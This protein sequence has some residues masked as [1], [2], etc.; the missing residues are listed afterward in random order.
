MAGF[1]NGTLQGGVFF[2]AKQFGSVL[3]GFGPP[4]PQAGVVG[5][6]YID[7]QTFNLYEKRSTDATDPWGNFIFVVPS[8]QQAQLKWFVP[9]APTNDIGVN[10]DYALLWAGF[11]N[12]GL[13]PLIFGP[14]AAGA[15]PTSPAAVAVS[16]NPL[17]TAE[18]SVNVGATNIVSGEQNN[19]SIAAAT[20]LTVPATATYAVVT[21]VGGPLFAT[22]DGSTPSS[23]NFAMQVAQGGSLPV[24]GGATLLA[25]K[26][27][28]TQMSVS[29]WN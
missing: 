22:Y 2:Q 10:G 12:Y 21:A 13:Q 4:V 15:W 23:T 16:L 20:G 5:D 29:Y 1:D 18:N 27:I 11:P 6:L 7:V 17:Y 8:A 3:R 19:V 24:Q 25:I 28:G 9:S 14:K 26:V